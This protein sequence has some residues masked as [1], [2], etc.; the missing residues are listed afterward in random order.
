MVARLH[1]EISKGKRKKKTTKKQKY[2]QKKKTKQILQ[3][4]NPETQCEKE[5]LLLAIGKKKKKTISSIFYIPDVHVFT[6]DFLVKFLKG[7]TRQG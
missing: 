2:K 1:Q 4:L 3:Q 5:T 7:T 6:S